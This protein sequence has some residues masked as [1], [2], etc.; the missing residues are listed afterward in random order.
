MSQS[1]TCVRVCERQT[2][3]RSAA[4]KQAGRAAP[5]LLHRAALVGHL[6]RRHAAQLPLLLLALGVLL[7]QGVL[8]LLVDQ[9]DGVGLRSGA[10]GEPSAV[11]RWQCARRATRFTPTPTHLHVLAA[12]LGDELG[13]ILARALKVDFDSERH[14]GVCRGGA[15]CKRLSPW[16][17]VCP[18]A[19]GAAH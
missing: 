14:G 10:R 5:L 8:N 1:A 4:G 18:Y 7:G 15:G 11:R 19:N 12:E 2:G 3:A 6:R 13:D 17:S 16:T 9:R